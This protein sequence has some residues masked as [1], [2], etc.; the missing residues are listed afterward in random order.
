MMKLSRHS[1][2]TVLVGVHF[3]GTLYTVSGSCD[4]YIP[5]QELAWVMR[6]EVNQV[7]DIH[8]GCVRVLHHECMAL[9]V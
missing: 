5:S 9:T 7:E 8:S 6:T 4:K 3:G 1:A 2:H